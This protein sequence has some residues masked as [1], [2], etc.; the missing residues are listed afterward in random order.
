MSCLRRTYVG[1]FV[2]SRNGIIVPGARDTSITPNAPFRGRLARNPPLCATPTHTLTPSL[3]LR[4]S[5][6]HIIPA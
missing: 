5:S 4:G 1:T 6:T 2:L 3:M